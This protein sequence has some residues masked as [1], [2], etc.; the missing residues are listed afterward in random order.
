MTHPEE[1]HL[2]A[3]M[4]P[5]EPKLL[6]TP[7]AENGERNLGVTRKSIKKAGSPMRAESRT[8]PSTNRRLLLADQPENRR[9]GDRFQGEETR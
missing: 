4:I 8:S 2:A 5:Q 6:Q 9:S 3:S 7:L 1:V